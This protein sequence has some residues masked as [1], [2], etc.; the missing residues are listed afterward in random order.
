[1]LGTNL[2]LIK[3]EDFLKEDRLLSMYAIII[4]SKEDFNKAITHLDLYKG[5][6]SRERQIEDPTSYPNLLLIQK[7]E[8]DT[9]NGIYQI[10]SLD[11]TQLGIKELIKDNASLKTQLEEAKFR[12]GRVEE[13]DM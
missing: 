5:S 13:M 6:V 7:L 8:D 1:M 3:L 11:P 4:N 2:E 10:R 12:L 9:L